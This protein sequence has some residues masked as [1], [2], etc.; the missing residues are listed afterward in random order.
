MTCQ[1]TFTLEALVLIVN[2]LLAISFETIAWAKRPPMDGQLVAEVGVFG[3]EPVGQGDGRDA[4]FVGGDVAGVDVHH[5]RRFDRSVNEVFVGWI[6]RVVDLEVF[7]RPKHG[8]G[9]VD[10]AVEVSCEG[11]DATPPTPPVA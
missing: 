1:E 5:L 6:E 3:L 7:R 9:H 10:V 11:G 2:W 4:E 8:A